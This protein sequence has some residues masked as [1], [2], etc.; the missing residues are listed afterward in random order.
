MSSV[1]N[2]SQ[3]FINASIANPDMTNWNMTAITDMTNILSN[4]GISTVNYDAAL[5]AWSLQTLNNNV[6]IGAT[7]VSYCNSVTERQSIIST[8]GWV[9]TGDAENCPILD[10]TPPAAPT[11]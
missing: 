3:M 4:S 8:Y 10:I 6:P 7:N 9:F 2:A 11:V 1:Q 5:S